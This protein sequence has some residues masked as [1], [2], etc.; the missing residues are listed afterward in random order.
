M[1]NTKETVS[2]RHNRIDAHWNAQRLWKYAQGLHRSKIGFSTKR[3]KWSWCPILNQETVSSWQLLAKEK[4]VLS[5]GVHWIIKYPQGETPCPAVKGQHKTKSLV[6]LGDFLFHVALFRYRYFTS[7]LPVY[8]VSY[9]VLLWVFF[10][11][12]VFLVSLYCL[13]TYYL[14]I[15]FLPVC[16]LKKKKEGVAL[17][18]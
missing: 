14:F 15:F 12:Y 3:K 17:D 5:N 4:L 9:F 8:Y 7:L 6:L 11:V 10:H 2:P 1:D 18:R 16:Y 13:S